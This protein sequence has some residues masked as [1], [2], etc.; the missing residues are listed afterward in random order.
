MNVSSARRFAKRVLPAGVYGMVVKYVVHPFRRIAQ[1]RRP[2]VFLLPHAL[3]GRHQYPTTVSIFLTTRC[4]LRCFICRRE[5]FKGEDF[6]FENIYKLKNAIRYAQRVDLT[7]WGEPFLYSR[8]EDVLNYTYSLNPR[9]DLIQITTNGTRLS[10]H[11]A[12]LLSGH[13]H[14]LI[15]SLNAATAETYNRDMKGGDFENTLSHVRAFMSVL[16]DRDRSRVNLHFVAHTQNF[17]EIPDF[18]VLARSL[19]IPE[20]S[21]GQYLVG[22]PE[23]SQYS[24]LQVKQ[25]F[26]V[27]VARAQDLGAKLGVRVSAPRFSEGEQ[28]CSS[29]QCRDPFDNCFIGVNGDV[30]PCCFC[31]SNSMGNVYETS[32]EAVWLG[33]AYRKL[34]RRRYLPACQ[35]CMPFIPLADY[36]AHFTADFK[37]TKEFEALAQGFMTHRG[38]GEKPEQERTIP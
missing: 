26:N 12:E 23:H 2:L 6:K 13:L 17:R 34:R 18:I 19:G 24:L 35:K 15:I 30:F 36:R 29:Q 25:D 4:N 5:G 1:L 20:V 8:F 21:I 27:V 9:E 16:T 10:E 32:F 11:A 28:P 33:D 22:I 7:G 31:G 14:S 38:E 37:E 3:V